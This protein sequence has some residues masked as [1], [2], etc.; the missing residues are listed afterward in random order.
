MHLHPFTL[1]E[2]ETYLH[3]RGVTLDRYDVVQTYML[4]GGVAYYLSYFQP[5]L[6]LAEN[7]DAIYFAENGFL[8]TEYD[9]LFTSLFA[10][11]A[12]YRRIVETL[13]ENRY[14]LTREAL[15]EK[16]G[17]ALGGYN[18]TRRTTVRIGTTTRTV[19]S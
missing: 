12:G 16:A 19:R 11:N 4:T 8:Q 18:V 5:G 3:R 2:T 17:I 13:S 9:R 15:A 1:A 10:D 14:G 6:S 7:I